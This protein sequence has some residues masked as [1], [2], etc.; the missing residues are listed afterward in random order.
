M[1]KHSNKKNALVPF[2]PAGEKGHHIAIHKDQLT[3]EGELLDNIDAKVILLDPNLKIKFMNKAAEDE[4]QVPLEKA[5][6]NNYITIR[7]STA[8]KDLSKNLESVVST[9]TTFNQREV[10]HVGKNQL[11]R[12]LDFAYVPVV[13][14]HGEVE[15]ILSIGKEVTEKV[16]L[17]LIAQE[18]QNKI[19]ELTSEIHS[20]KEQI[21]E[22][23]S[24]LQEQHGYHN[25]IGK[26]HRMVEIYQLIEKI[27]DTDTSVLIHGETG[28][29]K[30]LIAKA[31][32]YNSYRRNHPLISINCASLPETLLES[33]LFGHVKGAFT[34][35]IR[36]KK[37]KFELAHKGTLFL[38]ELGEMTLSTQ[39][40]LL[41]VIQER[42]FERLGDE[43][44]MQ[45][46]I[47]I[48]AATNQDLPQLIKEGKFRKDLYYRLNVI[49]LKIPSL[50]ER[51][52]DV[53]LLTK[54]FIDKL[55]AKYQKEINGIDPHAQNQ[56]M[57]HNWPGNVREL[58]AAIEKA[59]ILCDGKQITSFDLD[60]ID[61]TLCTPSPSIIDAS[62]TPKYETYQDFTRH[63]ESEEKEYFISL[64]KKYKG[65]VNQIA[66]FT[67][68]TR[69][70]ILNKMNRFGIDK[71]DFK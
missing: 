41:R 51:I 36:D 28:V 52:T 30:E 64:F 58:E 59:V 43:K 3:L 44:L 25:I 46:D 62:A 29:G 35:A 67:G 20:Q 50:R 47:R 9:Q 39:V 12:Y 4:L 5:K 15:G 40:K 48:L 27:A 34:G 23:K 24:H 8:Q 45:V 22:L 11:A 17:N 71:K 60:P 10:Q 57:S 2:N 63:Q 6:G 65:K 55:N 26:H 68:L 54:H 18:T 66:E 19:D 32:H 61:E 31:I 16:N 14:D 1:N 56:L 53:P 42:Q 38:D 69:R 70:T 21:L 7:Q 33:E 13:N 37:G 49:N